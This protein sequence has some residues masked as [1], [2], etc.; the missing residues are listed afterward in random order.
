[1]DRSAFIAR[2][3]QIIADAMAKAKAAEQALHK[4]QAVSTHVEACLRDL[5]NLMMAPDETDAQRHA[6]EKQALADGEA[7]AV[8]AL[9]PPEPPTAAFAP[10]E[11]ARIPTPF[12]PPKPIETAGLT[13]SE[14]SIPPAP[15]ASEPNVVGGGDPV[16]LPIPPLPPV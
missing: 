3:H 7:A 4:N 8:E 6:A 2:G 13:A 10:G 9:D 1:M 5:W 16:P 15:E 12:D 14:P 11:P